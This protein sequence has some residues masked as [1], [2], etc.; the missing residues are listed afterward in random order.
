MF[1]SFFG[2]I[3][4]DFANKYS[5][6]KPGGNIWGNSVVHKIT[7]KNSPFNRVSSD[8]WH[9]KRTRQSCLN[10]TPLETTAYGE[11]PI[12]MIIT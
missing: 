5:N 8:M 7:Q 4:Y 11:I 3:C 12:N 2:K 9:I 1:R 10:F 6:M